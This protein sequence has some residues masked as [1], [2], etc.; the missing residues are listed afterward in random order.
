MDLQLLPYRAT[1][2]RARFSN[3]FRPFEPARISSKQP[4]LYGYSDRFIPTRPSRAFLETLVLDDEPST[5]LIDPIAAEDE[6]SGSQ[7]NTS[8]HPTT[9]HS[10]QSNNYAALLQMQILQEDGRTSGHMDSLTNDR[11]G[12]HLSADASQ[13]SYSERQATKKNTASILRYKSH[14][15]RNSDTENLNPNF[16]GSYFSP[17]REESESQPE[18]YK[19]PKSRAPRK[20]THIPYKILDAPSLV[21]DYY[22]NLL[23][24]SS[25]N[26]ISIGLQ[27]A[28]YVWS[29][30]TNKAHKVHETVNNSTICSVGW[31]Q[32]AAHLAIGESTGKAQAL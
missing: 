25:N 28:V 26:Q 23:D 15:R 29:A 32:K 16:S 5:P 22:L 19:A 1:Q 10:S 21:D 13:N 9:G 27:N 3:P 11:A 31:D 6:T 14:K 18:N 7:A 8:G 17:M 4:R 20:I 30:A 2:D 12:V 24:W